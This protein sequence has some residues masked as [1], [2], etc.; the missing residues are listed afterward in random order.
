MPEWI[1]EY[2]WIVGAALV[3][4]VLLQAATSLFVSLRR[5]GVARTRHQLELDVLEERLAI[6]REIR[7]DKEH[8]AAAW[9]GWRKF[10]VQKRVPEPGDICSFYLAPHDRKELPGFKPGQYLTFNLNIEGQEKPII[11]CYSLSDAP[12]KSYYRVS[13]KR[14]PPPRDKPDIPP[15][16][17]SNYFHDHVKEGAIL[18][19]K[20]ASGHFFLD[21]TKDTPIVLIGGGVGLTPVL[22]MLNAIAESGSKRETWFFYGIRHGDEHAMREHL[23]DVAARHPNVQLHVCYSDPRDSDVEGKDYQHAERVSVDLFKRLLPSNNYDFLMCGPPPMMQSL[24]A[25]LEAWG[26][27]K[28]RVHL[29]AFG[30]A[31]V[32]KTA[33]KPK[34]DAGAAAAATFDVNFSRSGRTVAWDASFDSILEFAESH[35]IHIDSGCRAGN[36]GTCLTAVKSGEVEYS[37]DP[38][39]EPEDGS[40]L[41][42]VCVPKGPLDIDA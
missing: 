25:D 31:S 23:S 17:S 28:N 39:A 26:V 2:A 22:S 37:T 35:D 32:K 5:V 4:L 40:C 34:A 18:D 30:P 6:A 15:G 41:A 12:R 7:Q 10:E 36:C 24:T 42:C 14:V 27:P 16:L 9:N 13:I 19:V 21:M 33:P 1:S 20:A 29:E 38:G 3:G 8:E 11:R